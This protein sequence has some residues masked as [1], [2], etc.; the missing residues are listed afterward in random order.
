MKKTGKLNGINMIKYIAAHEAYIRER[1]DCNGLDSLLADHLEK[2]RWLQ[3][4]RLVH[5]LVLLLVAVFLMFLFGLLLLAP[6]NVLILVLLGITAI[7]L[8]AYVYHYY[9]L[10]NSV[11]HWYQ[12]ADDLRDKIGAAA[13]R[14]DPDTA[15]SRA[16][17]VR[18]PQ[19]RT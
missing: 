16:A 11:Q 8:A 12:I 6:F 7:L 15:A 13:A 5:L 19:G 2:I 14:Q 10:E 18:R 9:R 4:E 17:D 1:P 3:H